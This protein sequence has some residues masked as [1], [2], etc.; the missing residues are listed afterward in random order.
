MCKLIKQRCFL[1][2]KCIVHLLTAQFCCCCSEVL[3][4]LIHWLKWSTFFPFIGGS[5]ERTTAEK[6]SRCSGEIFN[7]TWF[8]LSQNK[9]RFLRLLWIKW[10][11]YLKKSG[12]EDR[13]HPV[14][15]YFQRSF[16]NKFEEMFRF[17]LNTEL[18]HVKP[19]RYMFYLMERKH[20]I[21]IITQSWWK[22][23]VS[24]DVFRYFPKQKS[25]YCLGINDAQ[26]C[27]G[28]VTRTWK[29]A[30]DHRQDVNFLF[31]HK[32]IFDRPLRIEREPIIRLSLVWPIC[33]LST[34][35]ISILVYKQIIWQ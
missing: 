12:S 15:L 4:Q 6:C 19:D 8:I 10:P 34:C 14:S 29:Q 22:I 23:N 2:K 32:R 25:F 26:L 1:C 31:H 27:L 9:S 28:T 3:R 24:S 33:D 21:I 11:I 20:I 5:I 30:N 18:V 16:C 17:H 35:M 7:V 13:L